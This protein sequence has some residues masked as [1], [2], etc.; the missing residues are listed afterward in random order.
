M[1]PIFAAVVEGL[2]ADTA[3]TNTVHI[4]AILGNV[5]ASV[6]LD[7]LSCTVR[8]L[9][10]K[11]TNNIGTNDTHIT[12]LHSTR[13]AEHYMTKEQRLGRLELIEFEV[14]QLPTFV[15]DAVMKQ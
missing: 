1:K 2:R 11:Y 15:R 7:E 4:H 13:W 5:P 6:T 8:G 12:P 14:L 9:W 10:C 3:H